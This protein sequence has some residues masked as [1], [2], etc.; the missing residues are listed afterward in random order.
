MKKV[1]K[2]IFVL[3]IFSLLLI[4]LNTHSEEVVTS[5]ENKKNIAIIGGMNSGYHWGT[6]KRGAEAAAREFNV[7]IEYS[8][9]N[10]EGDVEG[11]IKLVNLALE[12]KVDA[13]ILAPS[14]YRAMADIT[15][16]A[17]NEGIPVVIIDSEVDTDKMHCYIGTDNLEAGEKAGN[18][19]LSFIPKEGK[20][21]IINFVKGSKN[22]EEREEG[23]KSVL[24]GSP[25]INIV[26]NEYCYSD[27]NRA[28]SLT[29]EIISKYEDIDAIVALN[30]LSSE[31]VAAA[32]SEMGLQGKVKVVAFDSTTSEIEFLEKGVI[33]AIVIQ[34]PFSMGYLGVKSSVEIM[35]GKKVAKI[36]STGSK[37]ID[38]NNMDLPENQKLLFP[39]VK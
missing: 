35:N 9:P 39:F 8:A 25:K 11:Q 26:A 20:I 12:K 5:I 2:L 3:L 29:K 7:N 1:T 18:V 4:I 6:I 21:A 10:D 15:K 36:I 30:A 24:A 28:Y 31:G 33:Q 32:V 38:K 22:A 16:K 37:I 27:V 13:L 19:L 14:D 17:Y 34:N 23:I